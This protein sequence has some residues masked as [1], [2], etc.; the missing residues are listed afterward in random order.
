MSEIFL[1]AWACSVC[2]GD[3]NSPLSKGAIAGVVF[4]VGVVSVVLLTIA[5]TSF[6]W[7]RRAK[8]LQ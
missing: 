7:A 8:K 1:Q 2:F 5:F 4:M 6:I 3:P